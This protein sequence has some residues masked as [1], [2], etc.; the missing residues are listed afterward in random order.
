MRT[1]GRGKQDDGQQ[2]KGSEPRR[3]R[4][5]DTGWSS[6]RPWELPQD[7][8]KFLPPEVPR[9]RRLGGAGWYGRERAWGH[10]R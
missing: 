1:K 5:K 4:D 8:P 6:G 7:L 10:W 9:E 2:G 3:W